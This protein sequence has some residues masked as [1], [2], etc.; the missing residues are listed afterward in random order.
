MRARLRL[1]A[2]VERMKSSRVSVC[3][4]YVEIVHLSILGKFRF[5]DTHMR[6]RFLLCLCLRC[7]TA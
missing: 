4:Q 5:L 1:I 2:C 3:I 6:V 7:I